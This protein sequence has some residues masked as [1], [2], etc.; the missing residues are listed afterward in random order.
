MRPFPRPRRA[1]TLAYWLLVSLFAI[2][3]AL[4]VADIGWWL[5]R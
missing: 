1:V 3:V 2:L 5:L 4:V